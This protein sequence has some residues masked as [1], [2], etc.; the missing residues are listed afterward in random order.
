M[1]VLLAVENAKDGIRLTEYVAKHA[2]DQSDSYM[3]LTCVEP[4]DG[5]DFG[6]NIYG[7]DEQGPI[8]E[9]R[10]QFAQKLVSSIAIEL[11]LTASLTRTIET[12]VSI[13]QP[14][15]C[16]VAM[17][18]E[19]QADAVIVGSHFRHGLEKILLSST[20]EAVA[21]RAPCTVLV[22]R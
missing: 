22:L 12:K 1:K 18:K 6:L 14:Q 21:Y 5:D 16:I 3:V 11:S 2:A 17:A 7:Y 8:L 15:E 4:S 10:K 20:A 9:K 19:W 13:G